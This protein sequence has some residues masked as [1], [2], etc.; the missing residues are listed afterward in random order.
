MIAKSEWCKSVLSWFRREARDK[1]TAIDLYG[2]T[3]AQARQPSFFAAEGAEDTPEGRTSMII[4]HLFLVLDRLNRIA[5]KDTARAVNVARLL[6]EIFVTDIDDCLRE[7]GVGDLSVPKKVKRTAQAMGERCLA[8]Q[9]ALA[10]AED[11]SDLARELAATVPGLEH[12]PGPAQRLAEYVIR[13]R[14]QLRAAPDEDLLS[15][16]VVFPQTS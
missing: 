8:Y 13:A 3:V 15:G 5:E 10:A 7:M 16:R 1:R 12:A 4:L 14:G 9:R 6:S 11:G 2:A